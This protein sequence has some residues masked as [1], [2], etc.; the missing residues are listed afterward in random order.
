MYTQA[1][2]TADADISHVEDATRA[3]AFQARIDADDRS[4]CLR[5]VK[6][7]KKATIRPL[8]GGISAGILSVC[9][10][11]TGIGLKMIYDADQAALQTKLAQIQGMAET[12]KAAFA[13]LAQNQIEV[14]VTGV[15][16]EPDQKA[17]TLT[18]ALNARMDT[19]SNH[20]QQ[21]VIFISAP[22]PITDKFVPWRF[23]P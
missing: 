11:M 9:L 21:G 18:P 3:A 5:A 20:S 4:F 2:N 12:N 1:L 14:S 6:E 23:N 19:T 7:W 16:G 8:V 15:I 22:E 17:I 10:T 13:V